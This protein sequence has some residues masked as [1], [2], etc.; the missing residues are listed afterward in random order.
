[1]EPS[2]TRFEDQWTA[3]IYDYWAAVRSADR[4]LDFYI[5]LAKESKGPVLELGCGTG[6]VL[7]P[8]ARE[9]VEVAGLDISTHM[10]TVARRKL[11]KECTHVQRRVSLVQGDMASFSLEGKFGLIIAPS[12]AFQVLLER[13]AQKNCLECCARH[14]LPGGRLALN[15]FHPRLSRLAAAEGVEEPQWDF[16][17]PYGLQIRQTGHTAYDLAN[18]RL[19]SRVRYESTSRIGQ[20]AVREYPLELRYFFRYEM[21]WLL[22]AGGFEVEAVYGEF[23]RS[24]LSADSPE[25][26]FVAKKTA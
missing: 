3:E 22:E 4:D 10:L 5:G 14:L 15:V 26:I 19:S 16:T 13:D 25:M 7:F 21:E 24:P 1:M 12:R 18:Q 2:L 20:V 17:G 8:L 9:G 11:D 6:R 23:D